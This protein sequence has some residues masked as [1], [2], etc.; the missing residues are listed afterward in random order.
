M[1]RDT[2]A[3]DAITH[4][5]KLENVAKMLGHATTDMTQ[6]SYLLDGTP[7]S[8]GLVQGNERQPLPLLLP[9]RDIHGG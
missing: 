3:I 7:K 6:P 8:S 2:C 5:T 1:L 9:L 4:G